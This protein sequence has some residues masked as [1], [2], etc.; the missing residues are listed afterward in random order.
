MTAKQFYF[1]FMTAKH[2]HTKNIFRSNPSWHL[3]L[4]L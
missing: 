3:T 4:F 1:I 2:V